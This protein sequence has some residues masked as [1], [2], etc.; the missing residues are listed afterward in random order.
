MLKESIRHE[1]LAKILLHSD[2]FFNF[3]TFVEAGTFDIASDAFATFKVIFIFW[4]KEINF[5]Y[6]YR[7]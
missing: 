1:H 6:F 3:F 7:I 2:R 5:F 4:K